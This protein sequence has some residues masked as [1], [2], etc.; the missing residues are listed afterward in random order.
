MLWTDKARRTPTVAMVAVASAIATRPTECRAATSKMTSAESANRFGSRNPA[1][2]WA[3]SGLEG[4]LRSQTASEITTVAVGQ[5]MA[6]RMIPARV[7]PKEFCNRFEVSPSTF[8]ARPEATSTQAALRRPDN[9][10]LPPTTRPNKS[11]SPTG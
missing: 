10:A 7:A 5:A 2:R 4:R 3:A 11:R 8:R 9:M 6:L 1:G